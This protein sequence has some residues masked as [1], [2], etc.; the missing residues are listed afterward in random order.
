MS[1]HAKRREPA[2]LTTA[3]APSNLPRLLEREA[4]SAWLLPLDRRT[5]FEGLAGIS[6]APDRRTAAVF[7]VAGEGQSMVN[8]AIRWDLERGDPP[9]P[10]LEA[11]LPLTVGRASF[12]S[13]GRMALPRLV[14]V[15]EDSTWAGAA[16]AQGVVLWGADGELGRPFARAER[17]WPI[18][19]HPNGRELAVTSSRADQERS[20]AITLWDVDE[21]RPTKRITTRRRD[22]FDLAFAPTGDVLAVAAPHSGIEL[23]DPRAGQL[24][25]EHAVNGMFYRLAFSRDGERV[26]AGT[27]SGTVVVVDVRSGM[28]IAELRAGTREVIDVA[29]D[30]AGSPTLAATSG[31]RVRFLD[32]EQGKQVAMVDLGA[33]A[34]DHEWSS[35]VRQGSLGREVPEEEALDEDDMA[36]LDAYADELL[37]PPHRVV[38]M[39]WS[40]A[41]LTIATGGGH[42]W[43]WRA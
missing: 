12:G 11:E 8:H 17:C 9:E 10:R 31:D 32:I 3:E 29:F 36:E 14:R 26:A 34:E 7:L 30:P 18:A 21:R 38:S 27:A 43:H 5:S 19:F 6:V 33:L 28:R 39:S 20:L 24:V 23:W 42:V 16:I 41:G 1:T 37:G 40:D 25:H 4:A 22:V 13:G 35:I 15:E 2:I